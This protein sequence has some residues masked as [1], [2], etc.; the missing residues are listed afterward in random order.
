M[1]LLVSRLPLQCYHRL[2]YHA[3]TSAH[4]RSAALGWVC[5]DLW[6]WAELTI[7]ADLGV[8]QG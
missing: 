2:D 8:C 5:I 4:A 3:S 7:E 1:S 6:F